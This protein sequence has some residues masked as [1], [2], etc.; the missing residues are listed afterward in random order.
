MDMKSMIAGILL[1]FGASNLLQLAGIAFALPAGLVTVAGVD[2][3][4]LVVA[5]LSIGIALYLVKKK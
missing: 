1:A 2:I 4:V 5:I 3:G